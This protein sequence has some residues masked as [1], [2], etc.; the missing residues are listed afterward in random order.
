[1]PSTERNMARRKI[2]IAIAVTAVTVVYGAASVYIVSASLTPRIVCPPGEGPEDVLT[3]VLSFTSRADGIQLAGWLLPAQ[4]TRAVVLVHGIDADAWANGHLDVARAYLD[5]GFDVLLFDLRA[6]GRSQGVRI[7][8]GHL[9]R[10]DIGAAVD[11]LLERG[12]PPGRIAL[13]GTSYGAAM[14]LLAAAEIPQVGAVIADSAYADVRDLI[15]FEVGRRTRV[16]GFIAGTIMRPGIE[17]VAWMLYGLD[18][19]TLAPERVIA[20]VASRPL[21]LIHGDRDR[22]IPLDHMT[23]LEQGAGTGAGVEHWVLEGLGHSEGVRSGRCNVDPSPRRAE[24][25]S[26]VVSFLNDAMTRVSRD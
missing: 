23:R 1:M 16:P 9:E 17:G 10:G 8:L 21:L 19:A 12:I 22:V 15:A 3:E 2:V 6:H 11:L 13:H 24:F 20:R 4:G 14:V 7:S 18:L 5:A 26:R 25:L